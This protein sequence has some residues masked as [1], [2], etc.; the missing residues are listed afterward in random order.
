MRPLHL[1]ILLPLALATS[2]PAAAPQPPLK[3]TAIEARL[4]Y[5]FSGKLSD[6]LLKRAPPFSGWN[7]VIGEGESGEPADD[8]LVQIKIEPLNRADAADELY[9]GQPITLTATAGGKVV[10]KRTFTGTLIPARG[11]AWKA[12]YLTDVGCSG[13]LK[14]DVVS[15]KQRR[16]AK[17][18]FNCGE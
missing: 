12:M 17:L 3:V 11:A 2:L 8:L 5:Q 14:I 4:F 13:D 15:G 18:T 9:S 10:G 7:T 16:S 1:A 6:D